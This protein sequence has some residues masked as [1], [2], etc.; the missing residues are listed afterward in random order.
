[1]FDNKKEVAV[2]LPAPGGNKNVI[3]TFPTDDQLI[4]RAAALKTIVKNLGRGK[5]M[6]APVDNSQDID[7]ALLDKIKV[8]GDELDA[9]EAQRVMQQM[10]RIEILDSKREG[11]QFAVKANTPGGEVSFVMSMPSAKQVIDYRRSVVQVIDNRRTQEIRMNL[12]A[13]KELFA[14]LH[15]SHEGYAA[16]I[17]VN[18]QSAV[19]SEV[20]GL[21]DTED[22]DTEV[23]TF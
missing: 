1:M 6:T 10:L 16:D 20:L 11:S 2:I 14:S 13:S 12:H 18:H 9:Y 17:P 21:L 15:V 7:A 22:D 3:L 8:S 4:T 5:T 19:I 23:S